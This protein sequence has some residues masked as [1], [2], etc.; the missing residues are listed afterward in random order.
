[1]LESGTEVISIVEDSGAYLLF[2]RLGNV[3]WRAST[4]D[5]RATEWSHID[6]TLGCF[7]ENSAAHC[8]EDVTSTGL[9]MVVGKYNVLGIRGTEESDH[10][11]VFLP[12]CGRWER[13][14]RGEY[15]AALFTVEVLGVNWN[16]AVEDSDLE[17]ARRGRGRNGWSWWVVG[18]AGEEI[19]D[20]CVVN[21][22]HG[23]GASA[24]GCGD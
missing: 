21:G 6:V 4:V 23:S 24:G 10:F 12:G 14:L 15:S 1:M 5:D 2:E 9:G 13:F 18:K 7:N 22:W 3:G 8:V 20:F 11:F 16:G 19:Y 17:L